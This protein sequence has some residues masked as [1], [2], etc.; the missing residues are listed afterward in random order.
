MLPPFFNPFT[1]NQSCRRT[2]GTAA[3]LTLIC[4]VVCAVFACETDDE[5]KPDWLLPPLKIT[6]YSPSVILPNSVLKI[7][8]SGLMPSASEPPTIQFTGVLNG[9][10]TTWNTTPSSISPDEIAVDLKNLFDW[11]GD[12]EE[13]VATGKLT[14]TRRITS[15]TPESS[16]VIPVEF[17]LRNSLTGTIAGLD[18]TGI[19]PSDVWAGDLLTL[20]GGGFLLP[21]EGDTTVTFLD[22]QDPD[23]SPLSL[24]TTAQTRNQIVFQIAANPFG[25]SPREIVGALVVHNHHADGITTTSPA[26]PINWN[27]RP[28]RVDEL[29]P[30]PVSRGQRLQFVGKGFLPPNPDTATATVFVLDGLFVPDIGTPESWTAENAFVLFPSAITNGTSAEVTLRVDL[31]QYGRLTG[32][33]VA[34]GRFQGFVTPYLFLDT[35]VEAGIPTAQTLTVLPQLQMVWLRFL[36]GYYSALEKFGLLS[37]EPSIRKRILAVCAR[38]YANINIQFVDTKPDDFAEY[39]IVEIGG[40]DPNEAF[41]FGL[42]NTQG[43]DTG[44]VR[45]DD[46]VGGLNAETE[47]EGYYGYGGVFVE[48]FLALSPTL[49]LG[50][51]PIQTHRFDDIF[52]PFFVGGTGK[53]VSPEEIPTGARAAAISEAIRV[54]GNLIGSTITHEVGHTLGLANIAGEFH[55]I[56]DNPGWIMDSGIFRPFEERAEIDGQGP[57]FFSP[58]NRQYLET[59]LPVPP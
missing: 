40:P 5:L 46:V 7:V 19:D 28:S 47:K 25:I 51:L 26:W 39:S 57:G 18:M 55:N 36:P 48:S 52:A 37:V 24:P 16:E 20:Y 35:H 58:N 32:L 33:G 30:G 38:D 6:A 2:T 34:A 21:E 4:G 27:L 31:D 49:G 50:S 8:G 42:D 15:N 44:N 12:S 59:I 11:P 54:L 23:S 41:L 22:T 45:F 10:P 3:S 17:T 56:G 13:W 29:L 43:K 14:I 9:K 53:P 1:R